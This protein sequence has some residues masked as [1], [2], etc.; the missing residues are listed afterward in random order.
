MDDR[1]VKRPIGI[2]HDV[3][4]KEESI[5]FTADFVILDCEV[6]FQV[7]IIL[8]RSFLDIIVPQWIWIDK[9]K[10]RFQWNNEEETFK[11]CRSIMKNGELQLVYTISQKVES[12]SQVQI[13]KRLGVEAL[14]AVI[15]NF[16]SDCIKYY[17]SLAAALDRGDVWFKPKKLD[18]DMKHR[19]SPTAKPSI[20]EAQKLELKAL[21]HH[22]RQVF[23][24]KVAFCC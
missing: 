15:M 4:V 1:T 9:G 18:L 2:L 16:A 7:S 14:A 10:M 24:G 21:P 5:I 11:I 22:M 3:L 12:L 6:G 17:G 20:E 13:E 19:E 8:R 23:M